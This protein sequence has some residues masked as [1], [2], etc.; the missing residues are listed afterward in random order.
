LDAARREAPLLLTGERSELP[1]GE[2]VV[3]STEMGGL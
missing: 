1:L 2:C 3:G